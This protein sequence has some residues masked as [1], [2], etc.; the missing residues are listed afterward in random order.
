MDKIDLQEPS[1]EEEVQAAEARIAQSDSTALKGI[2]GP[3]LKACMTPSV[4]SEL[5]VN[6]NKLLELGV[7]P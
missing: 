2:P 6:Q 1:W 3:V 7:I 5:Q 4:R